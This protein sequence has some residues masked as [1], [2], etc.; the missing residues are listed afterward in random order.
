MTKAGPAEAEQRTAL[1]GAGVDPRHLYVDDVR[2]PARGGAADLGE[3]DQVEADI[4]PGSAVVVTDLERIGVSAADIVAVVSRL[5]ARG[6]MVRV[7]ASGK[8]YLG[9]DA[10]QLHLDAADAERRQKG[11]RA[12]KAREVKS[13]RGVRTGPPPKL[14]GAARDAAEV[15]YRDLEQP[16]RSVAQKHGVSPKT[17]QRLFGL[18]DKPAGRPKKQRPE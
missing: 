6:A 14:E 16:V 4:Q 7:L 3:R 10:G 18:R 13:A 12:A 17:L 15:D 2:I 8:L 9:V 11:L 1:V 5:M